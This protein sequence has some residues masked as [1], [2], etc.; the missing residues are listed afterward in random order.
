MLDDADD[1]MDKAV[2]HA[3]KRVLQRAH[4]PGGARAGRE[5]AGRLLRRRGAAAA[6]RRLPGARGPACSSSARTTR[7]SLGAIEKAIQRLATSG[8]N[9]SN[10]GHV[11]RLDVPAAH[12]GAPQ[13]A[14]CKVVKHMAEEGRVAVR[15]LRRAARHDLEG[16]AKDGDIP[17]DELT[18]AEKELDKLTHAHEAEIDKALEHK[19]ARAARGLTA[20]A[21]A[22]PGHA[23]AQTSDGGPMTDERPEDKR[24]DPPSEGVRIIGAEEAAEALE[25]GDVAQRRGD[26]QPRYGDRPHRLRPMGRAR[27]CASRSA[28]S[29]DP[30]DIE[31][32]PVVTARIRSPSRSSCRTGRSRPRARSRRSCLTS[33]ATSDEDADDWTSFATSTPRWRDDGDSFDD[34]EGFEDMQAWGSETEEE[35][36]R[37]ALDDRERPTHDD[38]FTFADLD[39]TG[40]A[41]RSVFADVEPVDER[42]GPGV[43]D[44]AGP[45]STSRRTRARPQ[46]PRAG[47]WRSPAAHRQAAERRRPRHGPGDHR[48]RRL[49]RAR[50]SCSSASG[51]P[52]P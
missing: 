8:L 44:D 12:R 45:T 27:C 47:R 10:D 6:A 46:P 7:A 51:P 16:S 9:P 42:F 1:K 36:D 31:R 38:Y 24:K 22:A 5:A 25:R 33:R 50:R 40:T 32:P 20:T 29:S 13:G 11:I 17:A 35:P 3:R 14:A 52:R 19:E 48:R 23:G 39:E 30:R 15:N 34:H 49:A 4:R 41:S 2:E 21:P 26:D 37:G 43:G 28:R 18:R